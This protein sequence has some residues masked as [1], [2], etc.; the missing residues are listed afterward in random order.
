MD[1]NPTIKTPDQRLP[2]PESLRELYDFVAKICPDTR[3]GEGRFFSFLI[4]QLEGEGIRTR[5]LIR[6]VQ[7][8]RFNLILGPSWPLNDFWYAAEKYLKDLDVPDREISKFWIAVHD[9][10]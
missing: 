7:T 8:N 5:G 10:D 3:H 6:D 4:K 2:R 1:P 9:I